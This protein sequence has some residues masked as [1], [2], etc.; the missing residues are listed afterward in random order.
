MLKENYMIFTNKYKKFVGAI[1]VCALCL[2]GF[3]AQGCTEDVDQSNRYTFTGETIVDYLENRSDS[4]GDFLTILGKATIGRESAGSIKHLLASYG[5]YTCFAPTDSAIR[6]YVVEQY[7]KWIADSTAVANGEMDPD[8][9]QDTG[10]HSPYFEDLTLAKC[11]EIAKN[12]IIENETYH[13]FQ[14]TE[15]AFGKPNM[16]DRYITYR[17]VVVDSLSGTVRLKLNDASTCIVQDYD[18]ENGVV[19]VLDRVLSP[20]TALGPDLIKSYEDSIFS[21]FSRAL[22]ATELDKRIRETSYDMEKTGIIYGEKK[23]REWQKGNGIDIAKVP[24]TH[25]IKYTILAIP[26]KVFAQYGIESFDDGPNSLVSFANKWYG[27]KYHEPTTQADYD[28]FTSPN[29]PLYR[30]M[31]YH[32]IDRQLQYSGGFVQDNIKIGSFDSEQA[33]GATKGI[34][35]YDYFETLLGNGKPIKCTKPYAASANPALTGQIVLNYGQNKGATCM[36]KELLK[37]INIRVLPVAEFKELVG[38]DFEFKQEATNAMIHPVSGILVYNND[39]MKGNI[40][41]ERMRWNFMSFFPEL[42]NNSV[43]WTEGTDNMSWCYYRIPEGYCKR[44]RFRA[45]GSSM[46][47]LYPH[48]GS[49]GSWADYQGDEVITSGEYDFEYRIPHVPAGTYELRLGTCLCDTRGVAQTYIDGKVTGIP[50]DLRTEKGS[51]LVAERFAFKKDSGTELQGD[52]DLIEAD[53]KARRNRGFMK[54]PAS[55]FVNSGKTNL[56]DAYNSARIILGTVAL[57]EGDHWIRFK[58]V[59][60]NSSSEFMHNYFEMVPK[61]VLSDPTKP[62]DKY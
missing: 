30:M 14:L 55:A 48:S 42:T 47:Y 20:S 51:D 10:V 62:E 11:T 52:P 46:Y 13:T 22:F 29:N 27:E 45:E 40:L 58:N 12:H 21:L 19:Q 36:N 37:H 60:G 53:D 3:L 2:V 44:I 23:Q 57:S 32:V 8:E 43:R 7:E 59:M 26:D 17:F 31:A 1:A 50:I 6:L 61:S 41:N 18:V 9:F 4:F 28:D 25:Y 35:R 34:D 24:D 5:R 33:N 39:E 54:G 56:R 15:G 49:E 38:G 16:N